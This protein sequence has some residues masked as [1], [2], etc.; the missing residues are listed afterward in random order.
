MFHP[1]TFQLTIN[2]ILFVQYLNSDNLIKLICYKLFMCFIKFSYKRTNIF[3]NFLFLKQF[4]LNQ[5]N[6]ILMEI[7]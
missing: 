2:N 7:K 1:P 6:L 4:I 5:I 3:N